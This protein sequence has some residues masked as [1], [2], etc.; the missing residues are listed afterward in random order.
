MRHLS[1]LVILSSAALLLV[2]TGQSLCQSEN[3]QAGK[4]AEQ[5]ITGPWRADAVAILSENGAKKDPADK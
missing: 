1:T 2:L 5:S 3:A 4:L